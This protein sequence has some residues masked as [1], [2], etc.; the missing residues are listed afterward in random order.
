MQRVSE[1]RKLLHAAVLPFLTKP[2]VGRMCNV[3]FLEGEC[4]HRINH[5]DAASPA[6][7][8]KVNNRDFTALQPHFDFVVTTYRTALDVLPPLDH[9]VS[10]PPIIF[11]PITLIIMPPLVRRRPLFERIKAYLDPY[12]FLLWLSEELNDDIYD[13]LLKEW[14]TPIGIALNFVFVLARGASKASTSRG[15]DDV[16]GDADVGRGS[17]RFA[18]VVSMDMP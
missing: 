18:W 6:G 1:A 13:E 14:A 5:P 4:V 8:S 11:P 12:D 16:F 9:D 3:H 7:P 15:I 10:N 2:I 17:G